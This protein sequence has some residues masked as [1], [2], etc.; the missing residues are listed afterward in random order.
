MTNEQRAAIMANERKAAGTAEC[1]A[2]TARACARR[3]RD[4]S[5][6]SLWLRQ[7]VEQEAAEATTAA[8]TA[9][10]YAAKAA[11]A[12]D[13]AP[14][15]RARRAAADAALA[16]REASAAAGRATPSREADAATRAASQVYAA[17]AREAE[18]AARDDF[19]D[20]PVCRTRYHEGDYSDCP[21]CAFEQG[22]NK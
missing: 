5:R 18:A 8:K 12:A 17:R 16:A 11:R 13:A 4:F 3:A 21:T 19:A 2:D 14:T 6:S 22:G 7:T 9:R 10:E 15:P 20:C 1:A